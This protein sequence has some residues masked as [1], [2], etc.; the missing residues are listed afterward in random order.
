MDTETSNAPGETTP[1]TPRRWDLELPVKPTA[2]QRAAARRRRIFVVAAVMLG[3]VGAFVGLLSWV[4]AVPRPYFLPLWITEYAAR[5]MPFNPQA[6]QDR[7][8][9]RAGGY[10]ERINVQ[11][12]ASQE[13]RLLE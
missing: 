3:L 13:R 6:T 12:F 11:A 1:A 9:L 10:F 7:E 8:A 5:P 4:H 2:A